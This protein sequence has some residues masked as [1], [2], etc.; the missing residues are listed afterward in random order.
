D[1]LDYIAESDD[2]AQLR[3][4]LLKNTREDL[5][6]VETYRGALERLDTGSYGRQSQRFLLA[7]VD[8]WRASIEQTVADLEDATTLAAAR[9]ARYRNRIANKMPENN[10]SYGLFAL[11]TLWRQS[12]RLSD[13]TVSSLAESVERARGKT[14][15]EARLLAYVHLYGYT[16]VYNMPTTED[17]EVTTKRKLGVVAY[18]LDALGERLRDASLGRGREAR[19]ARLAAAQQAFA[20]LP[21]G[22]DRT[23][24]PSAT[25]R[26]KVAFELVSGTSDYDGY[27][28]VLRSIE[29]S[30]R[31]SGP[32]EGGAFDDEAFAATTRFARDRYPTGYLAAEVEDYDAAAR[33]CIEIRTSFHQEVRAELE[34]QQ[35]LGEDIYDLASATFALRDRAGDR[36]TASQR[37]RLAANEREFQAARAEIRRLDRTVTRAETRQ[38]K[39]LEAC[40][41][42]L[43]EALGAAYDRAADRKAHLE[44]VLGQ[45]R[46]IYR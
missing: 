3:K 17:D 36:P 12:W 20:E 26:I 21:F 7:Q 13:P 35:E 19:L 43:S 45:A 40:Q 42:A 25:S 11:D 24:E 39:D 8:R 6:V 5:A 38:T 23:K 32:V 1:Y 34:R 37:R 14:V 18:A 2:V 29:E 4:D 30:L 28:D 31:F 46:R 15:A 27:S 16:A 10:P 41:P 22:L 9:G 33:A 44:Y